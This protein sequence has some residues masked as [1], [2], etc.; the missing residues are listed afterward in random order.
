MRNI[1]SKESYLYQ[2]MKNPNVVLYY[3]NMIKTCDID[4]ANK[5]FDRLTQEAN[6]H[7]R[8]NDIKKI[9]EE[10]FEHNKE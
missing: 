8:Y 7:P 4:I 1:M 3:I 9:Y 2:R 10:R 5:L 6:D